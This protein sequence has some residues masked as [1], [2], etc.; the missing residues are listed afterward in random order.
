MQSI[1]SL[2]TTTFADDLDLMTSKINRVHS[3]IKLSMSSK[4]NEDA[5]NSFVS[6]ML[7]KSER[8]TQTHES[9]AAF[10]TWKTNS[11]STISEY[12]LLTLSFHGTKNHQYTAIIS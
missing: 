5:H 9:K 11:T 12:L 2:S 3:L 10:K 4:F 7:I 8:N 6:I 1:A